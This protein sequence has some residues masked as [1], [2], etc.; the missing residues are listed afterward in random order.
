MKGKNLAQL[1]LPSGR[2]NSR[3]FV[4]IITVIIIATVLSV[5]LIRISLMAITEVSRYD[6]S[7]TD[8]SAKL[9]TESCLQEALIS[10]NRDNEYLGGVLNL[11]GGSCMIV[12]DGIGNSK[13]VLINSNF[14]NYYDS[15]RIEL[16]LKPFAIIN[17]D[18]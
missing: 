5:V 12:V 7:L 11:S 3:G 10:L 6:L 4:M 8:R 18:N 17:W 1:A 14:N 15:L 16:V 13:T 9:L 2:D